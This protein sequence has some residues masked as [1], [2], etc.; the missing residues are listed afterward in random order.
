[1]SRISRCKRVMMVYLSVLIFFG[2]LTRSVLAS[3]GFP[4][5]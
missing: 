3:T 4:H 1:M 5:D 2:F